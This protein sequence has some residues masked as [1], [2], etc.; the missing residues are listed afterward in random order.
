MSRFLELLNGDLELQHILTTET[1]LN[2]DPT[3][4]YIINLIINL[5]KSALKIGH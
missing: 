2:S 5:N 1:K 4:I 3:K